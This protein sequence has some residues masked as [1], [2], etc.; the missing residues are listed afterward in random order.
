MQKRSA[1]VAILDAGRMRLEHEAAPVRVDQ[2]MALAAVDLLAGVIAAR[3]AGLGRLDA[4][5]VDDRA[6]GTGLAPD[7]FAIEP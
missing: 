2:R 4:L 3:P 5:A 1:A 7:P 6:G